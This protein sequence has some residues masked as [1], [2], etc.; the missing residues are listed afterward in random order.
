MD[1]ATKKYMKQ[2]RREK[3]KE[4][5]DTIKE[6]LEFRDKEIERLANEHGKTTANVH[7]RI[8]GKTV[9]KNN[10]SI[11]LHN[12][13]IHFMG[14][15]LNEGGYWL[16]LHDAKPDIRVGKGPGEHAGRP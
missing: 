7:G 9:Y 12:V 4:F 8:N 6:A 15:E 13:K 11:N 16:F 1:T 5:E 14:A 2:V 10:H 3:E